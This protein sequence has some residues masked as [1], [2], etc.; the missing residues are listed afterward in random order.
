[1]AG[2]RAP[3]NPCDWRANRPKE[4]VKAP[5][6]KHS[7]KKKK[8][9]GEKKTKTRNKR[10]SRLILHT[11]IYMRA[12]SRV[13]GQRESISEIP[14]PG[15]QPCALIQPRFSPLEP[16]A[17][18]SENTSSQKKKISA[19]SRNLWEEETWIESR[20]RREASFNKY[21]LVGILRQRSPCWPKSSDVAAEF[22]V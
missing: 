3:T 7:K 4:Q 20:W 12:H 14:P 10:G 11:L 16:S 21:L 2:S 9:S 19:D 15:S 13:G 1:M 18:Q 8:S 17:V 22:A 6:A 5:N